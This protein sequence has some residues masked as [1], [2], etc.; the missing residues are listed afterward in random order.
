MLIE[1]IEKEVSTPQILPIYSE[2]TQNIV[3]QIKNNE[4]VQSKYEGKSLEQLDKER[5]S[6]RLKHEDLIKVKREL[7]L[8]A[9]YKALVELQGYLDNSL[10]F[11][12]RC[13]GQGG[14][15]NEIKK[16]IETTHGKKF[17]ISHFRQILYV[18]PDFYTYKYE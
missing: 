12:K 1:E 14:N 2:E 9:H 5:I 11:L 7:V 4:Q 17:E 8:P 18:A 6:M 10:D 13:R 16:S 3:N 15:F